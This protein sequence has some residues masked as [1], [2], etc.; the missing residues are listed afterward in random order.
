MY[1]PTRSHLGFW[2][3]HYYIYWWCFENWGQELQE[4]IPQLIEATSSRNGK[5]GRI[6]SVLDCKYNWSLLSLTSSWHLRKHTWRKNVSRLKTEESN[7]LKWKRYSN[8]FFI[9]L[10]DLKVT[11][12]IIPWISI[13]C[14]TG[15]VRRA[16]ISSIYRLKLLFTG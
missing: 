15:E 6:S 1:I 4:V 5:G 8:L 3:T 12:I 2:L 16:L 10:W 11:F 14:V 9:N 13:I 7:L